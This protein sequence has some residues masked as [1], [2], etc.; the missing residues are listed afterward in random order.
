MQKTVDR[1]E[2]LAKTNRAFASK[3][4]SLYRSRPVSEIQMYARALKKAEYL[5]PVGGVRT[6]VAG[7]TGHNLD[8]R[9]GLAIKRLREHHGLTQ[10]ELAGKV[11]VTQAAVSQ[12]ERGKRVNNFTTLELI[13][14]ALGTRLSDLIRLAE[15]VWSDE[16]FIKDAKAE[17]EE[18]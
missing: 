16:T 14:Q 13:A 10:A 6:V 11:S 17:L 7:H 2:Q 4:R 5:I 9:V 15:S 1:E 12:L 3:L 8:N 18:L